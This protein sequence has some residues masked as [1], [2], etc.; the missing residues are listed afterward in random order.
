MPEDARGDRGDRARNQQMDRS[1][2]RLAKRRHSGSGTL[3][4]VDT[5]RP[6]RAVSVKDPSC[7]AATAQ[8]EAGTTRAEPVC[9][10]LLVQLDRSS[11]MRFHLG[12][13]RDEQ[14]R[15][16]VAQRGDS[17]AFEE[18]QKDSVNLFSQPIVDDLGQSRDRDAKRRSEN[19]DRH[20]HPRPSERNPDDE[21]GPADKDD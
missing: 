16:V 21:N 10:P 13:V 6:G 11:S 9:R 7:G 17:A 4:M 3:A 8:G 2:H 12:P 19:A 5:R 18:P 1:Q 20:E 15:L 14:D